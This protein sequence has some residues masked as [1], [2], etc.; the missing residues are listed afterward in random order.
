M[1]TNIVLDDQLT[2]IAF[3]LTGLKTKRELVDLA[4]REL[5]R[6]KKQEKTQGLCTV[7][8]ALHQLKL[9]SDPFP[10]APRQNRS[11]PFADEL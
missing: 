2:H 8:S 4:L 11:N 7:F 10:E 6:I 1:R 5:I 3:L 9:D